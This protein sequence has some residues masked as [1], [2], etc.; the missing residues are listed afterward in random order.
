MPKHEAS[1]VVRAVSA[2][3]DWLATSAPPGPAIFPTYWIINFQKGG[4]LFFCL[5]LM[6]RYQNYSAPALMY[7]VAH[8][9]YGMLWLLKHVTFP[10]PKWNV[11][12]TFMSVIVAISLVLGPYW[13]APYILI[14]RSCPEPTVER[15]AVGLFVYIIGVSIMLISDVWKH[16]QLE[17]KKGLITAGP[18]ALVRHPNYSGEMMVYSGFAAMVPHWIPWAILAYIWTQLFLVNML[19]K[20][21]RMSRHKGW[22][23]YYGRTGMI[24]PWFFGLWWRRLCGFDEGNTK[25]D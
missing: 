20:E 16:V 19:V 5:W 12:Q 24:M 6:H 8:G 18:F 3:N 22:D 21:A 11:K 25:K 7:T 1:G 2:L 14:S 17:N 9:S 13:V 23:A 10:D 15:C 4:S